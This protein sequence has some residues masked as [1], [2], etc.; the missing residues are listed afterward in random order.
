MPPIKSD[1]KLATLVRK[2]AILK[3]LPLKIR[4]SVVGQ[5]FHVPSTLKYARE[6]LGSI[7]KESD[8]IMQSKKRRLASKCVYVQQFVLDLFKLSTN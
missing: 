4:V 5:N 3:I 7:S 8:R 2:Y 6:E 1:Y